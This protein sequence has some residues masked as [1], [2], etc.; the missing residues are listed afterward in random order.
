MRFRPPNSSFFCQIAEVLWVFFVSVRSDESAV[1]ACCVLQSS[2]LISYQRLVFCLSR[3]M[4]LTF[5][6]RLISDVEK[7]FCFSLHIRVIV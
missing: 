6:F 1:F 5:G 7:G 4:V 3:T 2:N